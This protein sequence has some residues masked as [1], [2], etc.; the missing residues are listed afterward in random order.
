MDNLLNRLTY[1]LNT[2]IPFIAISH[3]EVFELLQKEKVVWFDDSS[4]GALPDSYSIYCTQVNHAAF[5]LGYSYFEVFLTDLLREAFLSNPKMLPKNKQ[6]KFNEILDVDSYESILRLMIEKEVIDLFY[7]SMEK[8]IEYFETKLHLSWLDEHKNDFLVAS[9]LR[10]CIIHNMSR[11]NLPLSK[12]SEYEEGEIIEL[13][14][15]RVH[16]FGIA[17][18]ELSRNLYKQSAERY[19]N[20][21][22]DVPKK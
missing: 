16:S 22:R 11:A 13:S 2:L 3:E 4:Q 20:R 6:L 15:S 12:V 8:V 18:R 7:Q 14:S 19:F 17:A 1:Q 5:L 9:Y 21:V 10:N